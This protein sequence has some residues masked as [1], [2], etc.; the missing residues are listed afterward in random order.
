MMILYLT[1][2]CR[3]V[4][5]DWWSV[6]VT[7]YSNIRSGPTPDI[8]CFIL[9]QT[10]MIFFELMNTS[11]IEISLCGNLLRPGMGLSTASETFNAHRIPEEEFKIS[12]A[13]IIKNDSLVVKI[14]DKY[15]TW[16]KVAH[17][18]LGMAAYGLEMPVEPKDAIPV[19]SSG[20][21]EGTGLV[22]T[23]SGRIWRLWPIPF[24]RIKTL[25][26]NNSNLSSEDVFLDSESVFD[27]PKPVETTPTSA[28]SP[29]KQFVRTQ[30]PTTEQIASLNLKDG[31]NMVSFIFSTR[32]LGVQK[33][34]FY[35]FELRIFS[36]VYFRS[37]L[38]IM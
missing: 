5:M 14:E 22:S 28:Q 27:S 25:D 23:P 35:Y 36:L 12:A 19:D 24:R 3:A 7:G 15:F 11:G 20:P 26:H 33:V 34:I 29:K 6:W 8:K 9:L 30:V 18:V 13:S 1:E 17:I 4:K 16:D 32:V 38:I 37:L 10:N 31:Q 2:L 21:N